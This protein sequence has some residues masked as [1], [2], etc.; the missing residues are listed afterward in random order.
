MSPVRILWQAS[1][2]AVC[3][4]GV[5]LTAVSYANESGP[6]H[7]R[8]APFS[9]ARFGDAD[10]SFVAQLECPAKSAELD[11]ATAYCR[12]HTTTRGRTR[13]AY[14]SCITFDTKSIPHSAA[15][16][17]ALR[18]AQLIPATQ[19]GKPIS[20]VM[21]A[22]VVFDYRDGD[23]LISAMP[24]LG[25]Q[26]ND[27]GPYYV[28]PQEIIGPISRHSRRMDKLRVVAAD[29]LISTGPGLLRYSVA[30][31]EQGLPLDGR[32]D[33]NR[34][35]RK[36]AESAALKSLTNTRFLPGRAGGTVRAMRFEDFLALDPRTGNSKLV[37]DG[38][39]PAR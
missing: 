19:A 39:R 27:I 3:L 2:V 14:T 18:K 17:R 10:D 32:I 24:N 38:F 33:S 12:I 22:T 21:H 15:A 23:C 29:T 9:H 20:V 11:V 16:T 4:I 5:T 31:D 37:S 13:R 1:N 35:I 36:D 30:V 7:D 26:D 34:G 25:E 28:A 6:P 8:D